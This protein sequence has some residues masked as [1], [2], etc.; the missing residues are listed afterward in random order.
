MRF[1]YG[2]YNVYYKLFLFL[3]FYTFI[4]LFG[5]DLLSDAIFLPQAMDLY[6]HNESDPDNYCCPGDN[7]K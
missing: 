1:M 3:L 4:G 7:S 2:I 6:Y 5:L